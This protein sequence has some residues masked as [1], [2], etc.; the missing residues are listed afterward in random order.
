MYMRLHTLVTVM[1]ICALIYVGMTVCL[2]LGDIVVKPEISFTDTVLLSIP[3]AFIELAIL[4]S[5]RSLV[6]RMLSAI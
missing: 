4:W 2:Q 1:L 3:A 5:I 6:G